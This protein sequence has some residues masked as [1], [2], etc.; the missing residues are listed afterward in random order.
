ML[1]S[2]LASVVP[3]PLVLVIPGQDREQML[4]KF[5]PSQRWAE[6]ADCTRFLSGCPRETSCKWSGHPG[7]HPLTPQTRGPGPRMSTQLPS[8]PLP[9]LTSCRGIGLHKIWGKSRK[10]LEEGA[11]QS[12][13]H[14]HVRLLMQLKRM[15]KILKRHQQ[16]PPFSTNASIQN[17]TKIG[18]EIKKAYLGK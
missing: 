8:I 7:P 17:G 13:I 4:P 3:L 18:E 16:I 10:C 9:C 2:P 15:Q 5:A 14:R 11:F 12:Y 6:V 1:P